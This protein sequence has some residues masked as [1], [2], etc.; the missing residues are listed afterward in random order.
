MCA[1]RHKHVCAYGGQKPRSGAS[2]VALDFIFRDK[3]S[4]NVELIVLVFTCCPV[5]TQ[6]L[7]VSAHQSR[8]HRQIPKPSTLC[9]NW[10][11]KLRPPGFFSRYCVQ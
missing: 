9:V 7:P 3:V 10:G 2:S 6:H 4:L 5:D 11:S 1:G 8:R